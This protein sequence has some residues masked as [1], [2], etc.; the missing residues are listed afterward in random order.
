[1]S[2]LWIY[3]GF[4]I[5]GCHRPNLP[6]EISFWPV[7]NVTIGS[8]WIAKNCQNMGKPPRRPDGVRIWSAELKLTENPGVPWNTNPRTSQLSSSGKSLSV[9]KLSL[10]YKVDTSNSLCISFFTKYYS[11]GTKFK[12]VSLSHRY[13]ASP[14]WTFMQS[15]QTILSAGQLDILKIYN[16]QLQTSIKVDKFF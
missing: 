11:A 16:G 1:M 3:P 6:L 13:R 2:C 9:I 10:T 5:R 15:D 12:V 4:S 7:E 8:F 14:G